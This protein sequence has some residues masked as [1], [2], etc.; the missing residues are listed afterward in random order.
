MELDYGV[1][2]HGGAGSP[3]DFSDGCESAC[4]AAF[5]ILEGGGAALDAVTEACRLL[6]DDGRFNAGT[7][8]V[9]RIDGRT[10]EMD[11]AVMDSV[12][13]LG[14]VMN[15]RGIKN[16]VTVARGVTRSPHVALAGKGAEAYAAK[17]GVAALHEVSDQALK[18]HEKVSALMKEGRL[19]EINPLWKDIGP[20]FFEGLSC[21]TIGAVAVDRNGVFAVA[22]STG[23]AVPMLVGRVGDTPMIGCGFYAGPAGAVAATGIGEEII[24]RMLAK[25]VY[26]ALREDGDVPVACRDGIGLFAAGIPVGLIGITREGYAVS[27]NRPMAHHAMVRER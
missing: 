3:E 14:M 22:A 2:V 26:D 10:V 6:E 7:G 8:S 5:R 1:V 18:R 19:G 20:S 27:S 21:D 13:H 11:A 16:P 4:L 23:G 24:R 17:I 15:I 12:G 25:K 9:L